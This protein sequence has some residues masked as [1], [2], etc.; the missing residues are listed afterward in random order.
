MIRTGVSR[1]GIVAIAACLGFGLL[2]STGCDALRVRTLMREGNELYRAQKFDEAIEQYKKIL[3]VEPTHWDANYLT[4]VSWLALYHPGSTHE[5]DVAAAENA[6]AAF[7]RCLEL[8]APNAETKEKV[9]QYYLSILTSAQ[10]MDK[11]AAY[12]EGLLAQQPNDVQLVV[13]LASLYGKMANF[14]RA[15]E[16]Y[17]KRAEIEPKNKEAW[18]TIGVVCWDRAY[19]GGIMVSNEE[20]QVVIDEGLAALHKALELDPEYFDALSYTNLLH[21][22]K[23]KALQAM[24][25]FREAGEQYLFADEFQK[26]ALEVRKKMQDSAPPATGT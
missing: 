4:A 25:Q 12:L 13:A 10:R 23:A 16:Y 15:L 26:K 17:R 9:Q 18:Y 11:A 5:K 8:E 7:E 6:I 22:E 21:R 3:A 1:R 24:G 19:H 14:P 20:R 2:V